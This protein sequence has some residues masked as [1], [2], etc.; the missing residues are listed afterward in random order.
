M[1]ASRRQRLWTLT[2]QG[3]LR[4]VLEMHG[5]RGAEG[6]DHDVIDLLVDIVAR[7]CEPRHTARRS[8]GEGS[9]G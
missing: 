5:G 7:Y 4:Q 6:F 2:E 3:R 9:N 8:A 1:A